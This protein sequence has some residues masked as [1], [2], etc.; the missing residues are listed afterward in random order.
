[1][2]HVVEQKTLQAT[3]T[4]HSLSNT[5]LPLY[6]HPLACSHSKPPDP[7]SAFF[8]WAW[9]LELALQAK[10]HVQERARVH[11]LTLLHSAHSRSLLST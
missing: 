6:P 9:D 3:S 11:T 8:S 4:T 10:T 5:Q 1:M 7:P 2:W